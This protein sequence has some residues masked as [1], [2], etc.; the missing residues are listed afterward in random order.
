MICVRSL[1]MPTVCHLLPPSALHCKNKSINWTI[2]YCDEWIEEL[3]S[4]ADCSLLPDV[5]RGLFTF[6]RANERSAPASNWRN[7]SRMNWMKCRLTWVDYDIYL[8]TLAM[9]PKQ[10]HPSH[11][12]LR[13]LKSVS[14]RRHLNWWPTDRCWTKSS[15]FHRSTLSI[16][17][18]IWCRCCVANRHF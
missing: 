8:K 2:V 15:H 9:R 3:T 6:D 18:R 7:I 14:C 1:K 17:F 16:R 10:G 13:M 11:H 4:S 5:K 12:Y